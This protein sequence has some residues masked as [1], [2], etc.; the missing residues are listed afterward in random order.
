M[1]PTP[2]EIENG[3]SRS[4]RAPTPPTRANGTQPSTI[5]TGRNDLNADH[6]RNTMKPSATGTTHSSRSF[7]CS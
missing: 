1:N 7:A 3:I 2:A 4:H 5:T 6:S